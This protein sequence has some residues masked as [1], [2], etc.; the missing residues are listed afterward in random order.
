M[1]NT[2]TDTNKCT[3]MLGASCSFPLTRNVGV[4]FMATLNLPRFTIGL[5]VWLFSTSNI[6]NVPDASQASTLYQGH[7]N[8]VSP[9]PVESSPPPF[10]SYGESFDTSN[11]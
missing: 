3:P 4:P 11:R 5:S 7:Q 9:S 2:P 10:T 6:L 1:T 8:H